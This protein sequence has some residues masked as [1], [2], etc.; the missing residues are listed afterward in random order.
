MLKYQFDEVTSSHGE[1]GM[2]CT[3]DQE[4]SNFA[5]SFRS[6]GCNESKCQLCLA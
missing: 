1:A 2:I 3:D 4:L 6:Q 5:K